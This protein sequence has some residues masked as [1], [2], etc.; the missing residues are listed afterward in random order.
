MKREFSRETEPQY[1]DQVKH[2]N[3]DVAGVVIAIYSGKNT[4]GVMTTYLDVRDGYDKIY[5]RTPRDN[6]VSIGKE[7]DIL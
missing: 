2:L 5:Y 3:S 1:Q 4:E 6:W 7:E